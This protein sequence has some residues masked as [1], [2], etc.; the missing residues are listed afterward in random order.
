MTFNHRLAEVN[1]M[2]YLKSGEPPIKRGPCSSPHLH[3]LAY[4]VT[5]HWY[6]CG[7]ASSPYVQHVGKSLKVVMHTSD[8]SYGLLSCDVNHYTV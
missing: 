2:A 5:C 8:A 4:H 6:K 3:D 1:L 7:R